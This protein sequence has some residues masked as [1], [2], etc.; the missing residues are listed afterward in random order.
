MPT[1]AAEAMNIHEAK[2][3]NARTE[4]HNKHHTGQADG[5]VSTSFM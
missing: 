4:P 1:H 5:T 2:K 3:G